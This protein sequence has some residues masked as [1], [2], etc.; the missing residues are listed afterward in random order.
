M[1]LAQSTI[2]ELQQR[3]DEQIIAYE[4]LESYAAPKAVIS[5]ESKLNKILEKLDG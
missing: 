2:D 1:T 3:L 4:A 5:I